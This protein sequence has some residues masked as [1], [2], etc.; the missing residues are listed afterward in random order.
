[1]EKHHYPTGEQ[2]IHIPPL[3]LGLEAFAWRIRRVLG[4]QCIDHA[5]VKAAGLWRPLLKRAI[6]IGITGSAGK[7]TTKELLLGV[8]SH[9]ARGIA[10]RASL[11]ALPE[12]AKTILRLRPSHSFCVAELSEDR[13]GVMDGKLALLQPSIAVVTVVEDDHLAAFDSRDALFQEMAKLVRALPAGGTAVLN[14]DDERVSA[15]AAH[16]SAK[17]ITFGISPNAE[18]RAE[19]I[20]SVWPDRLQLTLVHGQERV[21]LATQLCGTHWIPSVLGAVGGG[22]ATGMTLEECAEGIATVAPFE[23]RMQPVTTPDDVTFIRDDFKAPL[24]TLDA[25]F[26][27]M[28]A[29]KARRKIVLIGEVSDIR[30]TKALKYARLATRALEIGSCYLCW[31]LG[32][33]RSQG[34]SNRA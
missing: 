14:A 19:N 24:W 25:C 15:M 31:A 4:D 10:N 17:V 5:L 8:L 33:Q 34:P 28:K 29:A 23:G 21:R 12:V 20:S 32:F 26:E 13:P 2:P 16:C 11:N 30:P 6:F 7:T 18:L 1:M 3:T 9:K 22:L 27:F